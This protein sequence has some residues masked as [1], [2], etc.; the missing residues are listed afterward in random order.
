[1]STSPSRKKFSNRIS[2]RL[3]KPVV[4]ASIQSREYFV[5]AIL[6]L[7]QRFPTTEETHVFEIPHMSSYMTFA[8]GEIYH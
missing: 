4:L 5:I 3:T 7:I 1:M 2:D 6:M 8:N